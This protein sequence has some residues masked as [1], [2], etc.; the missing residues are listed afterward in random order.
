M[1]EEK[2]KIMKFSLII[3]LIF[4]VF[5]TNDFEKFGAPNKWIT[6]YGE[7]ELYSFFTL[8]K[9]ANLAQT[10]FNPVLLIINIIII[11]YIL[12]YAKMIS[13]IYIYIKKESKFNKLD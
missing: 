3:S 7:N 2:R 1:K 9:P 10:H 8:L 12:L 13:T 4:T 11:Y 6:Y 5:S